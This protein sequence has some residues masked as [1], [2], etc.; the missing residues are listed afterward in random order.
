MTR[1]LLAE[2]EPASAEYIAAIIRKHLP[3]MELAGIAE[4]GA[5]ALEMMPVI[6]PDIVITDVAMPRMNGLMFSKALR[7]GWPGVKCVIVS[8]YQE[9]AY[10]REALQHGVNDYLLKPVNPAELTQCLTLLSKSVQAERQARCFG[11]LNLLLRGM[12]AEPAGLTYCFGNRRYCAALY[13]GFGLCAMLPFPFEGEPSLSDLERSRYVLTG[14][15]GRE[16]LVIRPFEEEG[17]APSLFSAEW[18]SVTHGAPFVMDQ[19]PAV[20]E[21]LCAWADACLGPSPGQFTVGGAPPFPAPP[22]NLPLA[23]YLRESARLHTPLQ[24]VYRH[25][26]GTLIGQ[27]I[28]GGGPDARDI[29]DALRY[30]FENARN[31]QELCDQ[32][33]HLQRECLQGGTH[34]RQSVNGALKTLLA[35]IDAHLSEPLTLYSLSV[36]CGISQTTVNRLFRKHLKTSF[37]SYLTDKRIELA[38]R[39]IQNNPGTRIKE[40]AEQAGFADPLYFSRVFRTHTGTPPSKYAERF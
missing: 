30:V 15:D 35:Y 29:S 8:G 32:I 6:L 25:A 11:I 40:V 3:Q 16:Y 9:F 7:E 1:I 4:D 17:N 13:R 19:L 22:E 36:S 34:E 33:L 31:F 39:I 10:A 18:S 23:Q 28:A 21:A 26:H 24:T 2:D 38:R 14:R 37:L 12:K 5:E 20:A 27:I